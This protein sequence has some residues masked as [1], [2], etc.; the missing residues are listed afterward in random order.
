MRLLFVFA[1]KLFNL[2][3]I[4]TNK[5]MNDLQCTS[6]QG[7]TRRFDCILRQKGVKKCIERAYLRV[8]IEFQFCT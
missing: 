7:F 2:D 4:G 3:I 5:C 1:C 8:K 6:E